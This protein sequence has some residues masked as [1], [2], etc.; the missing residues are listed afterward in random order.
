MFG[1]KVVEKRTGNPLALSFLVDMLW[2]P[3]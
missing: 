1:S 2:T 3:M